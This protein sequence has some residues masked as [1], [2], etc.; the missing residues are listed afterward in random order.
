MNRKPHIQGCWS[1]S[2]ESIVCSM[3]SAYASEFEDENECL[4][5]IYLTKQRAPKPSPLMVWIRKW[6][7]KIFQTNVITGRGY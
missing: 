4:E 7:I 2:V 1:G 3:E 5:C 6:G